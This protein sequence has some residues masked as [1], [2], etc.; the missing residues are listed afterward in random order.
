MGV[1]CNV[2][3]TLNGRDPCRIPERWLPPGVSASRD[4]TGGSRAGQP[5]SPSRS[6]S[7]AMHRPALAGPARR[8]ASAGRRVG[9]RQDGR[10]GA[11]DHRRDACSR[12][13][14]TSAADRGM[15]GARYCWCSRSSVAA[16]SRS[17]RPVSA[18]TSRAARPALR[19]ASECGTCSGSSRRALAVVDG[20]GRHEQPPGTSAVATAS[21]SAR[22]RRRRRSRRS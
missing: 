13:R 10:A 2:T 22:R 3:I 6:T 12:S 16:S 1:W 5:A 14:S 7:S 17:G 18:A 20:R 11:G 4:L 9:Q 19:A 8:P 21:C 15:A